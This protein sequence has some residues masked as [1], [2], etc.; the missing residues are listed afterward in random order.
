MSDKYIL[1]GHTP[2][3]CDDL[4]TW[5]KWLKAADRTVAKTL[6]GKVKISTVFIGLDHNFDGGVPLVFETVVFGG[7][8]DQAEDHYATWEEATRGHVA[9]VVRVLQ[10]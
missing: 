8:Y 7:V 3:V 2:I 6:V 1:K 10:P 5:A 4:D 9:M